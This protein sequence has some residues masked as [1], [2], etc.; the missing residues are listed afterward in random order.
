MPGLKSTVVARL[1]D[2]A[3]KDTYA[4]CTAGMA[5]VAAIAG[6]MEKRYK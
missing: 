2:A 1:K 4:I 6:Q 5:N 3:G